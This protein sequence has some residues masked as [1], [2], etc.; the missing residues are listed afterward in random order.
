MIIEEIY[1]NEIYATGILEDGKEIQIRCIPQY[2]YILK[3]YD[4]LSLTYI[5]V[6][7][8]G[9][10]KLIS[11]DIPS[12]VTK[13]QIKNNLITELDLPKKIFFLCCDKEV[14]GLDYLIDNPDV[15]VY[16]T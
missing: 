12:Q 5:P 13:I 10:K 4:F 11:L 3:K 6:H 16:L 2:D 1:A 15:E 7:I 14:K 8:L 9:M